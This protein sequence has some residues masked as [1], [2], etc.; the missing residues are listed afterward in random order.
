[1]EERKDK[2]YALLLLEIKK[3]M[4]QKL[5]NLKLIDIYHFL[6]LSL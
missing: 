5:I 4:D 1:L 6:I 2:G 3:A